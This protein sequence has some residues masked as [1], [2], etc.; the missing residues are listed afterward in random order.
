MIKPSVTKKKKIIMDWDT[1][2]ITFYLFCYIFL[3]QDLDLLLLH[4]YT[5]P[6]FDI[7]N[8]IVLQHLKNH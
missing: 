6:L 1:I 2:F 4:C 7:K 8:Q 3:P 5:R